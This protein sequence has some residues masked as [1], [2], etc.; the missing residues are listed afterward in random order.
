[1][2]I[3]TFID[4]L[5]LSLLGFPFVHS[6]IIH[7]PSLHFLFTPIALSTPRFQLSSRFVGDPSAASPLLHRLRHDASQNSR[8]HGLT[9]RDA[10]RP[11]LCFGVHLPD[12][13]NKPHLCYI[14]VRFVVDSTTQL[15]IRPVE[16]QESS[17]ETWVFIR[18]PRRRIPEDGIFTAELLTRA[19]SRYIFCDHR[20][21]VF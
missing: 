2:K 12:L 5:I 18:A 17:S 6:F 11:T 7:S 8:S 20:Q 14:A 21:S 15:V 13:R 10:T 16:R 3:N 19:Q 1:M 4:S 9:Q